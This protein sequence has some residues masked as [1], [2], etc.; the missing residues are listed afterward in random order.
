MLKGLYA[1]SDENLTPDGRL[2][3]HA[4]AV[5][6]GGAK[7]FQLRH[8]SGSD[9]ALLPIARE[10]K[11]LCECHNALF[12]VNDRVELAKNA[13]A[14]GLHMGK[15]DGELKAA[16]AHLGAKTL[17]GVSCYGDLARARTMQ[18][19]GADYV[20]FG[21]FFVSPTKPAAAVVA[22]S[23]LTEAKKRLLIP[24]CAIGGITLQNAPSLI[25]AGADMV[26]VISDLWQNGATDRAR[27]YAQLFNGI[28]P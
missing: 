6:K 3:E 10:L 24:L 1:I 22:A 4:E 19:A 17:I 16:R 11:A 2:L 9:E 5:L 15:D 7:L 18:E 26:A 28:K 14:H 25:E 21:S 20:A 8:K 13:Q 12:I 27:Q 23:V